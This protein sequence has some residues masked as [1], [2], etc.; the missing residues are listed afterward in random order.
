MSGLACRLALRAE[1]VGIPWAR[2][3][4]LQAIGLVSI[5][6]A[7]LLQVPTVI[8]S[9]GTVWTLTVKTAFFLIFS[10]GV[11]TSEPSMFKLIRE[12][13]TNESESAP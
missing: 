3:L 1:G 2:V 9:L 8:E 6:F 12:K 13:V 5:G 4:R 7:L 10:L 11:V